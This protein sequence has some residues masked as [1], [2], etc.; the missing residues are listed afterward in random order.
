MHAGPKLPPTATPSSEA[1]SS[2]S[3][4]VARPVLREPCECPWESVLLNFV[5]SPGRSNSSKGA[6][7]SQ[8]C[9]VLFCF[10]GGCGE[11]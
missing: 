4:H 2:G 10:P 5:I 11:G 7:L 6:F 3:A 8:F 1:S 9:S